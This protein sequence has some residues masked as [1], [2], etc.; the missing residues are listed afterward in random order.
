MSTAGLVCR[1]QACSAHSARVRSS[2]L[3]PDRGEPSEMK[4]VMGWE[5]SSR[6]TSWG[7][8]AATGRVGVATRAAAAATQAT[9]RRMRAGISFE[10]VFT[11]EDTLVGRASADK[12][13]LSFW[14]VWRGREIPHTDLG[15]C[16][17]AWPCEH[18]HY[19][20]QLAATTSD[21]WEVLSSYATGSALSEWA[22][23]RGVE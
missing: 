13:G 2:A 8:S 16:R 9:G 1:P 19:R 23:R 17:A 15:T 21:F 4:Y 3:N 20:R 18:G 10:G 6:Q 11:R 5:R 22:C 12:Q 14:A 7:P